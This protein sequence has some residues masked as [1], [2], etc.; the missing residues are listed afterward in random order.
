MQSPL[1]YIEVTARKRVKKHT[2]VK[3]RADA[4][5]GRPRGASNARWILPGL[6]NEG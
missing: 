2:A 4:P 3:E 5:D 1:F 6:Q